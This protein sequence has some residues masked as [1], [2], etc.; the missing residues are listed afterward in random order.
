MTQEEVVHVAENPAA[1]NAVKEVKKSKGKKKG[2]GKPSPEEIARIRA[3]REAMREAKRQE[4]LERG[5]DPD[6]PPELQFIRRNMLK[7]HE[8]EPVE[9]LKIKIMSY[10]CLAQ[11]LIRR[12]LFPDSGEA[13]KWYRRSR[14]LLNEFKHYDPDVLCLQEIDYIQYQSFWKEEFQKLGYSSQFHRK[15]SKNHGV[16]I[17]W[18]HEK[19]EMSDRMLIDFDSEKSGDIEPRT[20]TNNAALIL[21]LKFTQKVKMMGKKLLD[22][23]SGI[24][25]GTTHLFWHP[26][27]TY[28]RTRQCY[29]VLNKMKEFMHRV[30]VLQNNNDGD[31]SH[32]YPFF[33]GDFNSQPFDSPYLSMTCKPIKYDSRAKTVIECSTSFK[34]SKKRESGEDAEDEEGGNIEK[35]GKDQPQTPVPEKFVANDEQ[36]KLVS[37]MEELHNSLDMRAVSLYSVAYHKVHPENSGLDNERGE[38]EISNWAHTWRGLLDYMFMIRNWEFDDRT[39]IDTLED[40]ENSNNI[41]IRGLLRMPPGSEMSTHGQPHVGEYP[42]DHLCLLSEVELR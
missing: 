35:F 34:F 8:E 20:T 18:K 36:T 33:C 26:F 29:V 31:M 24:L 12:K 32:W 22:D 38:P 10:N 40:F 15:P 17:I 2:K 30:N 4:M 19:F 41:K 5:V 11:A 37:Q 28:E 14:V 27:G 25:V 16:C 21:A 13:L 42:S 7:L 39:E 9:G 6:C 3:E 23:K 1:V